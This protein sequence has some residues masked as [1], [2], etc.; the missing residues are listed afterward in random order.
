MQ[1]THSVASPPDRACQARSCGGRVSHRSPR[2]RI[3]WRRNA[4][5]PHLSPASGA[6][7]QVRSCIDDDLLKW[8][9]RARIRPDLGGE[10]VDQ[11][12][13]PVSHRQSAAAVA[14]WNGHC[15][16][17]DRQRNPATGYAKRHNCSRR[18]GRT[19]LSRVCASCRCATKL[20][21]PIRCASG[22]APSLTLFARDFVPAVAAGADCDGVSIKRP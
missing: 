6:S 2:S 21:D 12:R 7:N 14:A 13:L 22:I 20:F 3:R 15:V 17:E 18:S 9:G 11:W 4:G 10:S 16:S 5:T 19:S 1:Q 8:I